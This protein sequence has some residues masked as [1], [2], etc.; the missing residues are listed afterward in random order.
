MHINIGEDKDLILENGE[1]IGVKYSFFEGNH[2]DNYV[3][4]VLKSKKDT[5]LEN[6][7]G[8]Y[9]SLDCELVRLD[10][11]ELEKKEELIKLCGVPKGKIPDIMDYYVLQYTL[12]SD[13][14]VKILESFHVLQYSR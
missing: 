2:G 7:K 1:I 10:D 5:L 11:L 3:Y 13:P 6:E 12:K 9:E 8:S 14:D 4:L